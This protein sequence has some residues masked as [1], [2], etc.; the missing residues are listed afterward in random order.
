M[1]KRKAI[2][3]L[4]VTISVIF[5]SVAVYAGNNAARNVDDFK[6]IIMG[7][8]NYR[9]KFNVEPYYTST[10]IV[11]LEGSGKKHNLKVE[12]EVYKRDVSA[13]YIYYDGKYEKSD[14]AVYVLV[15]RTA[16]A[17]AP[18]SKMSGFYYVDGLKS[19]TNIIATPNAVL[20]Y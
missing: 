8:E 14:Y 4:L 2:C 11:N 16:N 12:M 18:I 9:I 17:S 10:S 13:D 6:N 1:K 7:S 20:S 3:M 15:E 5:S 19:T